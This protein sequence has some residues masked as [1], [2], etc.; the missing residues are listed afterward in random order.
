MTIKRLAANCLALACAAGFP[1]GVPAQSNLILNPNFTVAGSPSGTDWN[2]DFNGTYYYNC[3][4]ANENQPLMGSSKPATLRR[5]LHI[6][7][8]F[9]F[10]SKSEIA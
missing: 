7:F 4:R 6:I 9:W 8:S 2:S 3:H 10:K 5:E 1:L